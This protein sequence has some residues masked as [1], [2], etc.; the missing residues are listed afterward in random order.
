[1]SDPLHKSISDVL[2][3]QKET[4]SEN[5]HHP[6]TKPFLDDL[7]ELARQEADRKALATPVIEDLTQMLPSRVRLSREL[8]KRYMDTSEGRSR[9]L[10]STAEPIRFLFIST[11][12]TS[13]DAEHYLCLLADIL[14]HCDGTEVFD[15]A[16]VAENIRGLSQYVVNPDFGG[17]VVPQTVQ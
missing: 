11:V 8:M 5:N 3:L 9:L 1:M 7:S 15:R 12:P 6:L 14:L 17:S 10:A 16:L 4:M 2:A 13:R